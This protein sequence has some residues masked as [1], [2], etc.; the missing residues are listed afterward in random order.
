MKDP[1]V[2][3]Q[4]RLFHEEHLV[5]VYMLDAAPGILPLEPTD[6]EP[7]RHGQAV[8]VCAVLLDVM[9]SRRLHTVH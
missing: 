7:A 6:V 5:D 1:A 8:P 2:I 9:E 4:V 3:L